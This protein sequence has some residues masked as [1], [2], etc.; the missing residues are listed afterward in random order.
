MLASVGSSSFFSFSLAEFVSAPANE[1]RNSACVATG[2]ISVDL[3][4]HALRSIAE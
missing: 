4:L 1:A 2:A 3:N